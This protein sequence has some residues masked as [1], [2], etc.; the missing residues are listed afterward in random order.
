MA[1]LTPPVDD[2]RRP[3]SPREMI[4]VIDNSGSMSGESM[5]QAK[6]EPAPRADDADAR[7]TGST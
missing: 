6:T 4:F 1:M 7:P 3:A 2:R 5:E